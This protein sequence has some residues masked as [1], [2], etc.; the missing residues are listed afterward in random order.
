[1]PY[2]GILQSAGV[3]VLCLRQIR[4]GMT[5]PYT[6]TH[7]NVCA[8]RARMFQEQHDARAHARTRQ[9]VQPPLSHPADDILH[10]GTLAT[11]DVDFAD[12]TVRRLG[13]QEISAIESQR[14]RRRAEVESEVRFASV[15]QSGWF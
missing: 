14:Q 7:I 9:T 3:I 12:C 6:H 13:E 15:L 2:T 10:T 5:L 8:Q 1:M 4:S 11:C